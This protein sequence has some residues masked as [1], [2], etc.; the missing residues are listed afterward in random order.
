MFAAF[1]ISCGFAHLLEAA[2]VYWP[3]YRLTGVREPLTA[4]V[5]WATVIGLIR[6][7]QGAG[8]AES[9]RA[10]ERKSPSGSERRR[11]SEGCWSRPPTPW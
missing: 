9:G 11:S 8:P 4:A 10:S 5:S 1:T 3:G 6:R 2:A 7:P